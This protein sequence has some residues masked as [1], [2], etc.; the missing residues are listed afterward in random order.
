MTVERPWEVV[1]A[2]LFLD[3]SPIP[4]SLQGSYFASQRMLVTEQSLD[5]G[6][7]LLSSLGFLSLCPDMRRHLPMPRLLDIRYSPLILIDG[8][9]LTDATPFLERGVG[10]GP[11]KPCPRELHM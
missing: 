3:K 10:Y 7:C 8:F 2:K 11:Q 4:P 5:T 1:V 9:L 6:S